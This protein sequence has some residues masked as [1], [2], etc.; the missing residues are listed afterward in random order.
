MRKIRRLYH[1]LRSLLRNDRRIETDNFYCLKTRLVLYEGLSPESFQVAV[2]D[3]QTALI[4]HGLLAQKSGV[5]DS[6]TKIAVEKFQER[7]RLRV[8]GIVGGIT[9]AALMYPKLARA[10]IFFSETADSVRELQEILCQEKI[11]VEVDGFFGWKTERAV[12]RFQRRYGLRPD[13]VCGAMTWAVLLGLI[14]IKS[15]DAPK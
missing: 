11:K 12:R 15:K 4:K 2:D 1:K 13:G 7:N 14:P 10:R 5:F 8:D 9:W 3:L 6:E